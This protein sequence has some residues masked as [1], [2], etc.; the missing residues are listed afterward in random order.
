MERLNGLYH[1]DGSFHK[2][3]PKTFIPP[4]ESPKSFGD[5]LDVFQQLREVRNTNEIW[6]D[7]V[8]IRVQTNGL[9]FFLIPF[10]DLHLGSKDTDYTSFKKYLD[11]VKNY[12]VSTVLIGDL[13]DNFSPTWIPP[14]M[15]DDIAPPQIQHGS[16]RAF[17]KEYHEKI[18]A[19]YSGNHD[20]ATWRSS[21]AEIFNWINEDQG[22]PLLHGGGTINLTVDDEKYK[23]IGFHRIL[24]FHS[25]FNPTHAGKR[26]LELYK[27]ADAIISGHHH[28]GGVEKLTHRDGKTPV[29]VSCGTFKTEDSFQ[30]DAGRIVPFD[31]FYP[32]LAFF[33]QRHNVEVIEDVDTAKEMIDS[34]YQF[35]KHQAVSMLGMN[36][37][38]TA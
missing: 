10:S 8:D 4:V 14:G 18:L 11:Y 38:R 37:K 34:I 16:L 2:V 5:Y 26:A 25:N 29:I 21:G 23:I 27:D 7:E 6:K 13:V 31:I 17:F 24:L 28:R 15:M 3:T 1:A 9:P 12:P 19:N 30:K 32:T 36:G 20:S 33:P 35:H 22:V